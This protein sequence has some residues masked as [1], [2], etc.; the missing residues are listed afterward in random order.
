MNKT[1]DQIE[2]IIIGKKIKY[3][4]HRIGEIGA[5]I[6]DE[7]HFEDGTILEVSGGADNCY[8]E[9][10]WLPNGI[11]VFPIDERELY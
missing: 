6:L 11:Q 4:T 3:I 9:C 10:L 7:I 5:M 1:R 2:N 8:V